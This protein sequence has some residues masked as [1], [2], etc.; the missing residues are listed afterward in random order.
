MADTQ[1]V[2][3]MSRDGLPCEINEKKNGCLSKFTS[4][5]EDRVSEYMLNERKTSVQA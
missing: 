5:K 2:L 4:T 3:N 1:W